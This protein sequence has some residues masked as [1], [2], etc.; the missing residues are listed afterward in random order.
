LI[1]I[2]EAKEEKMETDEKEDGDSEEKKDEG[3]KEKG[4]QLSLFKMTTQ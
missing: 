3:E 2:V 1:I 4:A